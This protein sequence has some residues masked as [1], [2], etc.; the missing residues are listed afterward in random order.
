MTRTDFRE[1]V[2]IETQ[3]ICDSC[4]DKE[5]LEDLQVFFTADGQS[6]IDNAV[7]VKI[8]SCEVLDVPLFVRPHLTREDFYNVEAV[9]YFGVTLATYSNLCA[10]PSDITGLAFCSKIV[11]LCGGEGEVKTFSSAGP[12][13]ELPT[14]TLK[15][16][17]P[18]SLAARVEQCCPA[19]VEQLHEL[20][21][22]IKCRFGA[23]IV[24]TAAGNKTVFATVGIFTIT[25]LER[26]AQMMIPTYDYLIPNRGCSSLIPEEEPCE[27]F[28]R[29]EFPE[30]EFVS[31]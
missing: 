30:H 20:P 24:P 6:V 12:L 26:G 31:C 21:E 5:C 27:I 22:N 11:T 1:A 18:I 23:E 13:C 8:K 2:C 29:M 9:F 15:C 14:A 3:K 19:F 16:A 28:S 7:H 4:S 10:L 17:A 25:S